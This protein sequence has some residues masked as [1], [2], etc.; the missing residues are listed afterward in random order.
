MAVTEPP[1]HDVNG[2][3]WKMGR[4]QWEM[5]KSLL[6]VAGKTPLEITLDVKGSPTKAKKKGRGKAAATIARGMPVM[7]Y[8]AAPKKNFLPSPLHELHHVWKMSSKRNDAMEMGFIRKDYLNNVRAFADECQSGPETP[9][10]LLWSLEGLNELRD[11]D[12][13]PEIKKLV[14]DAYGQ[15][16]QRYLSA[17][18]KKKGITKK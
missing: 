4:V 11:A 15:V 13:D 12:Q 17:L 9:S 7:H 3:L 8:D 10:K 16:L 1:E 18:N 6:V 2:R 14:A 5:Y